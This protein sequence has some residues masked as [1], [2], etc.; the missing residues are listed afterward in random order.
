MLLVIGITSISTI[1]I[2][3]RIL[4]LCIPTA[5]SLI[6]LSIA[7]IVTT[8]T[9]SRSCTPLVGFLLR[10]RILHHSI[11]TSSTLYNMAGRKVVCKK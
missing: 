5:I 10:L 4:R 6:T 3:V 2:H 1:T 7:T 11:S 8:S 9:S